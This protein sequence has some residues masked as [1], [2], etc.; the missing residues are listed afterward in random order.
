MMV[1]GINATASNPELSLMFSALIRLDDL[2]PAGG[3][4]TMYD[5]IRTFPNNFDIVSVD[6]PGAALNGILAFGKQS[7][8]SGQYILYT[9][10]VTEDATGTWLIDGQPVENGRIY[11]VG[12]TAEAAAG[13]A[14]FGVTIAVT[15]E[16]DLQELLIQQL[17]KTFP[18][19]ETVEQEATEEVDPLEQI[20]DE[21]LRWL[22][23]Q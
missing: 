16:L 18:P 12:T 20:V 8:G 23:N 1:D 9:D 22:L 6:V 13:F 14:N 19:A 11:R 17:H 15:H 2:I 5:V 3:E 10:N 7:A 21:F 4:F